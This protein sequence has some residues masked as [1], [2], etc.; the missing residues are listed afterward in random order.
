MER[1]NAGFRESLFVPF[2]NGL[3]ESTLETHQLRPIDLKPRGLNS[4]SFHST[5]PV[6]G[7]G[8]SN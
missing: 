2:C 6:N 3:S 7:F 5:S 4:P 8:S 1:R